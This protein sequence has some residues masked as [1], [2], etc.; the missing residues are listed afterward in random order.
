MTDLLLPIIAG[1]AL[2][3]LATLIFLRTRPQESSSI[4]ELVSRELQTL[5]ST[6]TEHVL[7]LAEQKFDAKHQAIAQNLTHNKTS[8]EELIHLL[9]QDVTAQQTK[10]EQAERDRVGSFHSLKEMME[11]Q[12]KLTEQLS[13]TT[14]NLRKVLS[15]NQLRGQFGEQVA[16]DLLKMA[17][18][19]RGVDYHV[20]QAQEN[21][22]TRPDFTV[23]LPDGVKIHI[24]AKFPYANLQRLV[25]T[26]Q[27]EQKAHFLKEFE[28]DVKQKVKQVSSRNYINPEENTVDFVLLFIP[29]EM[30]FSFIYDKLHEV[31]EEGLRQKVVFVG[32][33]NFTAML[34]LVRQSY[35]NFHYQKN[36]R[37]TILRIQEF[38]KEFAKYNEEFKKIGDRL[39]Q[40]QRQY[41]SVNTT[42]TNQL[43]RVIDKLNTAE[44]QTP[45]LAPEEILPERP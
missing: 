27:P 32:P 35:D 38:E 31:W 45:L 9:K 14:D 1:L 24:D 40:A 26:E 36:M 16:E 39:D 43:M 13:V 10:L 44:N 12:N 33:F 6:T 3:A 18:F 25:E 23:L 29:N 7:T 28:K 21:D 34:R 2:G 22:T 5:M 4:G 11:Q 41:E 8:I 37:G 30:I 19:V 42:R 15:N 17:G 20:N